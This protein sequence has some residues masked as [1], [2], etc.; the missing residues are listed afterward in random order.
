MCVCV[1]VHVYFG[2]DGI[3]FFELPVIVQIDKLVAAPQQL[4]GVEDSTSIAC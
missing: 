3:A 4:L 2:R 1:C